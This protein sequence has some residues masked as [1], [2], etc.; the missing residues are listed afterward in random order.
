MMRV[1][2][3]ILLLVVAIL[4]LAMAMNFRP[5]WLLEWLPGWFVN[6]DLALLLTA[7]GMIT[8]IVASFFSR[9]KSGSG[10]AMTA[11][12]INRLIA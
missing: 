2:V 8:P 4:V 1:A 6:S 11:D 5:A 12:A 10:D 9:S 3:N 7:L